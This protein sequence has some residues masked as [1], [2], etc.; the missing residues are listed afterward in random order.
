LV[1]KRK[2]ITSKDYVDAVH[3]L[4]EEWD[5]YPYPIDDWREYT[6]DQNNKVVIVM[7]PVGR[8]WTFEVE[9]VGDTYSVTLIGDSWSLET[10]KTTNTNWRNNR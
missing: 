9:K 3:M 6:K 7:N 8:L 10:K 2:S 5:D 4:V 1:E